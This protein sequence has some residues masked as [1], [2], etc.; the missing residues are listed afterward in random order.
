MW[1]KQYCINDYNQEGYY[2][3]KVWENKPSLVE[4]AG[5]PLEELNEDELIK[6]VGLYKG[7]EINIERIIK[8]EEDGTIPY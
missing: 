5:R 7:E 3:T 1:V 8:V 4:I 2:S 6:I